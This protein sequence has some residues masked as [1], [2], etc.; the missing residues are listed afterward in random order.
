MKCRYVKNNLFGYIENTL[1]SQTMQ[2][3]SLHLENC[4]DCKKLFSE[5][6]RTYHVYDSLD[7]EYPDLWMGIDKKLKGHHTSVVEFIPE[8]RVFYRIA[9]SVII[10]IGIGLGVLLGGKYYTSRLANKQT[11]TNQY[12]L[13]EYYTSEQNSMDGESDLAVLYPNE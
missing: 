1:P 7:M 6:E 8:H 2:E 9:A 13:P 11:I 3:V 12:G 5:V 10:F 4:K